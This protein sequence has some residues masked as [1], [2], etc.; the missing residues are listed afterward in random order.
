MKS[1]GLLQ[2]VYTYCCC[3]Y[4]MA[5]IATITVQ[6]DTVSCEK[7]FSQLQLVDNTGH[8]MLFREFSQYIIDCRLYL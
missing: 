1:F 3:D 7:C 2:A 6:P 4:S 8:V 5:S